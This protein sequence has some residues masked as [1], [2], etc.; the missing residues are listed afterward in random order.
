MA[1][2]NQ[3]FAQIDAN[4]FTDQTAVEAWLAEF[5]AKLLPLGLNLKAAA[6]E[7]G[8]MRAVAGRKIL[9]IPTTI[10]IEVQPAP[11]AADARSP[12]Q[13][14]LQLTQQLTLHDK[15]ADLTELTA[16]GGA[17]SISRITLGLD[18]WTAGKEAE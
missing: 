1:K 4:L 3:R 11:G 10:S 15:R 17:D 7:K 12:Y 8:Q 9:V 2:V 18:F 5:K 16:E 6:V 13:R 14:V